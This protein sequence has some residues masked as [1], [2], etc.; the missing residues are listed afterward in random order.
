M[1]Y[2]PPDEN[3]FKDILDTAAA[4]NDKY[5]SSQPHVPDVM[6][7]P[8]TV[9]P[10]SSSLLPMDSPQKN[11]EVEE[12]K[13]VNPPDGIIEDCEMHPGLW[14]VFLNNE[15]KR[16]SYLVGN[17]RT[18]L[19]TYALTEHGILIVANTPG[20]A[21]GVSSDTTAEHC[22][23]FWAFVKGKKKNHQGWVLDWAMCVY[24]L[25]MFIFYN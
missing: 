12:L 17:L 14:P 21:F 18:A 9:G 5:V 20:A 2:D 19:R 6:S 22:P 15:E 13:E 11:E 10:S 1:D 24:Y 7:I 16:F 8:P 25:S 3:P 23:E 4:E